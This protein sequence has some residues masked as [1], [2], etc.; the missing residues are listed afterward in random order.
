[1][2]CG[3]GPSQRFV[4]EKACRRS[5]SIS[6]DGS[7]RGNWLAGEVERRMCDTRRARFLPMRIAGGEW[8]EIELPNGCACL[9]KALGTLDAVLAV[10]ARCELVAE[11]TKLKGTLRGK[12]LRF[13]RKKNGTLLIGPSRRKR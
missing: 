10:A 4:C 5:L 1:M 9:A 12:E 6:G 13:T 3:L 8:I 7:W 11:R 2:R